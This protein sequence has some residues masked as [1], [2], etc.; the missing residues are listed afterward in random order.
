MLYFDRANKLVA[1]RDVELRT[2]VCLF[3]KFNSRECGI[4]V[5]GVLHMLIVQNTSTTKN[6]S[7]IKVVRRTKSQHILHLIFIYPRMHSA[8]FCAFVFLL[9]C[10]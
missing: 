10:A 3:F 1:V 5:A 9:H 8:R 4:S 6:K 7:A 2:S